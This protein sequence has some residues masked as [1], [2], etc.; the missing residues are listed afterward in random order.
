MMTDDGTVWPASPQSPQYK[1]TEPAAAVAAGQATVS[2]V[3]STRSPS[4]PSAEM[5]RADE[6]SAKYGL[7]PWPPASFL[8]ME[9]PAKRSRTQDDDNDLHGSVGDEM[10]VVVNVPFVLDGDSDGYDADSE[11]GH[12]LCNGKELHDDGSY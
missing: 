1:F 3:G 6:V 2:E 9:T 11:R 12:G 4:P 5:G 10:K 7:P 8:A